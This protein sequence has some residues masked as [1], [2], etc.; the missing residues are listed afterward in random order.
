M[1]LHC[2]V[3]GH[4]RRDTRGARRRSVLCARPARAPALRRMRT[5]LDL[6]VFLSSGALWRGTRVSQ[7]GLQPGAC[8][9]STSG[10]AGP[11]G[12]FR[13]CF[14]ASHASIRPKRILST[15]SCERRP[16]TLTPWPVR[17]P[18]WHVRHCPSLLRAQRPVLTRARGTRV[19]TTVRTKIDR[20]I[21]LQY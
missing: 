14:L 2:P 6:Y 18:S 10:V 12:I 8:V 19:V 4:I 17:G 20:P 5:S 9:D 16:R 13:T 1:R 7:S 11:S 15:A 21:A 3:R